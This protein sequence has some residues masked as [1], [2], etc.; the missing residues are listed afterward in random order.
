MTCVPVRLSAAADNGLRKNLSFSDLRVFSSFFLFAILRAQFNSGI[1][2][3][4]R[5]GQQQCSGQRNIIGGNVQPPIDKTGLDHARQIA[6]NPRA[7]DLECDARQSL[8]T[9]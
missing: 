1:D 3:A 5:I 7:C 2:R 4:R 9:R 6:G 8:P